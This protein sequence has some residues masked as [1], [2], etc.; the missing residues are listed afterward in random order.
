MNST[1]IEWCDST[2]NPV[3]GCTYGCSFCYAK[4]LNERFSYIEDFSKPEFFPE[5]LEK[6]NVKNPKL[7]FMN[8][9]SDIADWQN[10]W[11]EQT[12]KAIEKNNQHTYLFLTK[13]PI[14][15]SEIFDSSLPKNVWL[16]ATVTTAKDVED[17]CFDL[18]EF[19][20]FYEQN[21]FISIEPLLEP[22]SYNLLENLKYFNWVIIGAETGNQKEKVIPSKD[23]IIPIVSIC[24]QHSI[25]VFMKDSL[26]SIIGENHIMREFPKEM[27]SLDYDHK[28]D[29]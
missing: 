22:I 19:S 26:I 4:R 25:P 11:V 8:S 1:K 2:L 14:C 7:I 16:G 28:K 6:L 13:R 5:R 17:N 29:Y 18:Y 9:M 3:V 24:R 20:Q 15:Y 21:T 23:W 27:R 10:N 12:F